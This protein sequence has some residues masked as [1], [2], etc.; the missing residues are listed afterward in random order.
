LGI[1]A[2]IYSSYLN[3]PLNNRAVYIGEIGLNG[4]VRNVSQLEKRVEEA[5]RLG[6]HSVY[7][8]AWENL[9]ISKSKD[10]QVQP[11]K[12]ISELLKLK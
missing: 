10:L 3:Q 7:I 2:A 12:N 9:K 6:F 11:M 5:L 8:P 1:S 4:Q